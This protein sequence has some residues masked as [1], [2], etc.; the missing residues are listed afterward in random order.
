MFD[1]VLW[2]S[3]SHQTD[4][5]NYP[6]KPPTS[7]L[8]VPERHGDIFRTENKKHW[9]ELRQGAASSHLPEAGGFLWQWLQGSKGS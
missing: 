5:E 8:H 7:R 3:V 6:W 4:I 1:Q 2:T 9:E